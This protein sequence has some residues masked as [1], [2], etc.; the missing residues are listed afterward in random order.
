MSTQVVIQQSENIKRPLYRK[1]VRDGVSGNYDVIFEMIRLIRN[2]VDYD[3][4]IERAAKQILVDAHL[5]SNSDTQDQIQAVFNFVSKHT[6]YIQD[7]AGRIE[8]LKDARATLRDGWGDCDDNTILNATLLGCLGFENVKIAMAKYSPSDSTFVHVYCVVYADNGKRYVLDTTLPDKTFNTEI[9]P[10]EVKEIPVFENVK[11]LDGFSGA[12]TNARHH[13]RRLVRFTIRAVPSACNVLPFGFLASSAIATGAE[14]MDSATQNTLSISATASNINAELDQI[15]LD[16]Y[17]GKIAYD[18]AKTEALRV[19]AQ[20]AAINM[21]QDDT[22]T[23][24]V[25]GAS[26]KSK[27]DFI[28]NFPAYA[29]ANNIR[30]VHL[31]SRLMLCAGIILAGGTGYLL[32]RGYKNARSKRGLF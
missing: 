20:L 1:F 26:I 28:N 11:G 22:Y 29:K 4:G 18:L 15:I 27:L 25:V 12:Y 5:D 16:L 19:A 3:Q 31:D 21:T 17:S 13:A 6:I 7:L 10:Y 14:L 32:Y 9:K 8:S 24:S 23:I 2:S 30:I